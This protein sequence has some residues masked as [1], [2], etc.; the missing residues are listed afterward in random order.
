[1]FSKAIGKRRNATLIPR[2]SRLNFIYDA[3][4]ITIDG[5]LMSKKRFL[6]FSANKDDG[7]VSEL[8][9]TLLALNRRFDMMEQRLNK[10]TDLVELSSRDRARTEHAGERTERFAEQIERTERTRSSM[11][12][13][14]GNGRPVALADIHGRH[15]EILAML[16][17]GGFYTYKEM[18]DKLSVSQSRVR[19]YIAELRNKYNIPLK[20]VRDAEGYKIGV[21]LRFV[22]EILASK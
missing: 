16:I 8:N 18:A 11:E 13:A 19:A 14:I 12:P 10:L 17:N 7:G 20:Q 6:D 1:L 2:K 21:E 9:K 4:L 22:E 15:R 3:R 5:F